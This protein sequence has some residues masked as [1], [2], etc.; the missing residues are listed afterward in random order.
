MTEIKTYAVGFTARD[1]HEEINRLVL[2]NAKKGRL[3]YTADRPLPQ[4]MNVVNGRHMG[5]INRLLLENKAAS[6]G[7]RSLMWIYGADAAM[8]GLKLKSGT[9]L[10]DASVSGFNTEPV[11]VFANVQRD[12]ARNAQDTSNVSNIAAEGIGMDAQPVYLLD[13]FTEESL[14]RAFSPRRVEAVIL[15]KGSE[16]ARRKVGV[17]SRNMTFFR[18]EYNSGTRE[19]ELRETKRKN[20][21]A[22]YGQGTPTRKQ[23]DEIKQR[24]AKS[25]SPEESEIF[26]C[27]QEYFLMQD[28]GMVFGG[29]RTPEQKADR[30]KKLTE[31]FRKMAEKG[32]TALTRTLSQSLFFADR[33]TH[34][35]FAY[36]NIYKKAD[37]EVKKSVLRPEAARLESGR[38]PGVIM[39]RMERE[40]L[41]RDS[42]KID[43]AQSRQARGR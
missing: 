11:V 19:A 23:M 25:F 32:G 4:D 6:I 18:N 42:R 29:K 28:T 38:Q 37:H 36:E 39:D 3:P 8:L 33:S 34:L 30:A 26:R 20:V 10:K 2:D 31:C 27:L 22:N 21:L 13:Q 1:I 35:D 5:D 40:V 9:E 12:M 24:L 15:S 14:A 43:R 16:E 17:I 41:T 7:A